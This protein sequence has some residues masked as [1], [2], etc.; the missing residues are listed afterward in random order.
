[1]WAYAAVALVFGITPG[2]DVVLAIRH[3]MSRGA[4]HGVAVA[5]GAASGS[6]AWGVAAAVGLASVVQHAP[7][8]YQVI[9]LAG[10]AY[11]I[12]LGVHSII[13]ARSAALDSNTDRMP[14]QQ[15][16]LAAFR[17]GLIADLLN[18]KMGAFYLALI[19]QFIP[20]GGDVFR[21]SMLFMAIELIIAIICLSGYA[22]L[23][24]VAGR[25]LK[26]PRVMA[27]LERGL[28]SILIGLGLRVA[29]E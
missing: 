10:G 27:W 23:A 14:A 11:L 21:W 7:T 9:K 18:P 5:L 22:M 6:L 3:S 1:M 4:A 24:Q 19:P 15:S 16:H 28:G 29:L 12:C 17:V 13:R 2:P 26:R 20:K 25:L 8:V